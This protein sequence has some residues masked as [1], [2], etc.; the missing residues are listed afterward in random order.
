MEESTEVVET[1]IRQQNNTDTTNY[2]ANQHSDSRTRNQEQRRQ[3]QRRSHRHRHRRNT[4]RS[5][6]YEKSLVQF[7]SAHIIL[8]N[9]IIY[10]SI[11]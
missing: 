2:E 10:L 4:S 6:R 7:S 5:L 3:H 8:V 11:F 1:V 9:F